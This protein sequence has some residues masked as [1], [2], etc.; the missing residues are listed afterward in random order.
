MFLQKLAVFAIVTGAIAVAV[1][2]IAPSLIAG[3]ATDDGAGPA[4]EAAPEAAAEAAPPA[5]APA[6]EE[7]PAPRLHQVVL[8]ADQRGHF[9]AEATINGRRIEAMI[10]T[11]ATVVALNQ[12]TAERLGIHL[13]SSAFKEPLSTGN[14]V[15][16]AAPVTLDEISLGDITV[17]RVAAVVVP[18][19][20]LPTNL[21]G[22]S[23]LSRL[24]RYEAGGGQL[25]LEQ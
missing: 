13:S 9:V 6:P 16:G 12:R 3:F 5:P 15:V 10:D 7:R 14:G 21:L 4:P 2:Q 19:D 1:P 25:M 11:G 18:G 23:Y 24:T 22:M 8:P 20:A 17:R